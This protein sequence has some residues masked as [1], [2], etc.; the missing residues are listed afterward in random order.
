MAVTGG[1]GKYAGA[2][3]QHEATSARRHADR[4]RLHLRPA[5]MAYT[6]QDSLRS[7]ED[8]PALAHAASGARACLSRR[9]RRQP[10]AARRHRGDRRVLRHLQR[11]HP[12]QFP[13]VAGSRPAHA[14][15][16]AVVAAFL[17]A[18][19][20]DCISFGQNMTTLNFA[21]SAR[22]RPHARSRA[23]KC[24][25]RSSITR[26]IAAHGSRCKSAASSC[27]KYVCGSPAC[28]TSTTWRRRSRDAPRCSRWAP[29]RTPWARS[30]TSRSRGA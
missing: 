5:V 17:G 26:R 2:Q 11:Q 15:A 3:G 28:S 24:S 21:L 12:R 14:A 19:S 18:A 6:E 27:R 4:L 7:T 25:S 22:H 23:T 29:H 10:G 8:F 20:G 30:M 9:P 16:R 13:A 1:T